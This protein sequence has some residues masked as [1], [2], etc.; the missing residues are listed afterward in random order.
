MA[1]ETSH[2]EVMDLS[3]DAFPKD[4]KSRN[5]ASGLSKYN[6]SVGGGAA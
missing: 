4:G 2:D 5:G 6:T 3:I 1:H